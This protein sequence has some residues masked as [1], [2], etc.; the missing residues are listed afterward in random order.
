M[1]LRQSAALGTVVSQG[2]KDAEQPNAERSLTLLTEGAAAAMPE[3]DGADYAG[4]RERVAQLAMQTPDRLPRPEKL[5][6]VRRILHEFDYYRRDAENALSDRNSRWRSLATTLFVE[7]IGRLGI[8]SSNPDAAALLKRFS[9]LE[10]ILQL[11]KFSESMLDFLHP[12]DARGNVQDIASSLAKTDH[13]T[14]NL[15]AAGLLGG[16]SAIEHVNRILKNAGRGFI[17]I[18]RLSCLG[19]IL[20]RFGPEAIDDCLM[21]VS[22]YLTHSLHSDDV[23]YH[24]SDSTLLAVLQGRISEHILAAELNRVASH[25]RDITIQV[26]GRTIMLRVPLEFDIY[27]IKG[28]Q[29]G[30]DLLKLSSE[31]QPV[32]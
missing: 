30:E 29:C 5:E 8:P 10:T 7:L 27:P 24:W 12:V 13:S 6:T 2:K 28:L 32:R 25:N 20:D 17:A 15:N 4:F 26:N 21:A 9:S 23:I 22:A 31:I 1:N 19:M 18:F 14:A 16:G 3:I 11:Q